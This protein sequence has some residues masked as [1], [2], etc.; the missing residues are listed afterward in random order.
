MDENHPRITQHGHCVAA[1]FVMK[2]ADY[3]SFYDVN[4]FNV[5]T[6]VEGKAF[7]LGVSDGMKGGGCE[8]AYLSIFSLFCRQWVMSFLHRRFSWLPKALPD[9]LRSNWGTHQDW[10]YFFLLRGEI[11]IVCTV[12][13]WLAWTDLCW[14]SRC[15]RGT[16][17]DFGT[18]VLLNV[19]WPQLESDWVTAVHMDIVSFCFIKWGTFSLAKPTGL[20]GFNINEWIQ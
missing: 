2:I 3:V 13:T 11:R 15:S 5:E 17:A 6:S 19:V 12:K 14:F 10:F 20:R 8:W 7:R 9:G 16:D 1:G 4:P 18:I